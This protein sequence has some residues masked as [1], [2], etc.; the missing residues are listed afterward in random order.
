MRT[1][2]PAFGEQSLE[3]K[4]Q[5]RIAEGDFAGLDEDPA[6]AAAFDADHTVTIAVLGDLHGHIDLAYH[7]LRRWQVE[8]KKID[9]VLQVG[10]FG[11]FPDP[12]R[13][14]EETLS[15]AQTD[16]DELG[17]A[18][19]MD[20]GNGSFMPYITS[21]K[22]RRYALDAP[23]WFI[24]GNH[25]DFQYLH[26]LN[27]DAGKPR[28]LGENGL[29]N[30]L[31]AGLYA[32]KTKLGSMISM[33]A[34]GGIAPAT[35]NQNPCTKWYTENETQLLLKHEQPVEILLTHDSSP[36][37]Y[38]ENAGSPAVESLVNHYAPAY[39]FFGHY[40]KSG[41][42]FGA[43]GQTKTIHLNEVNFYQKSGELRKGCMGILTWRGPNEHEFKMV[44]EAW[45]TGVTRENYRQVLA[46]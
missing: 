24:K 45:M 39:H 32:L 26:G 30:Y 35:T 17:F 22:G 15:C 44:K 3:E 16:P 19:F 11:A 31:P 42:I 20:G 8:N 9:H 29:F 37:V 28:P 23:W 36:G 12:S 25:E 6:T 34:L 1:G 38:Y 18:A 46:L 33:A 2:T 40:H 10:D 7:L 21:C 27:G 4:Y 43:S 13:A 41:Q 14:D 5:Q